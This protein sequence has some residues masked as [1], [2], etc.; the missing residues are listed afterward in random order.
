[1]QST[2]D[3]SEFIE[4]A[5][6]P[7]YIIC[8][9]IRDD[10]TKGLADSECESLQSLGLNMRFVD[11][12]R[13]SLAAVIDGGSVVVQKDGNFALSCEYEPYT[14]C[15]IQVTSAGYSAG[16][17]SSIVI[18]GKEYSKNKRGLNIVVYDKTKDEVISSRIFD[19]WLMQDER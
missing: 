7:N 3:L 19:T 14:N 11:R 13:T 8:L 15:E 17:K 1:M 2:Q 10:A 5:N 18:N 6:N 9:S 12:F 4:L 16:N